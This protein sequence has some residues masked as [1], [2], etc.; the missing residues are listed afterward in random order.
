MPGRHGGQPRVAGYDTDNPGFK[1][2]AYDYGY[3]LPPVLPNSAEPLPP[4]YPDSTHYQQLP[5]MQTSNMLNNTSQSSG[6]RQ[7][8]MHHHEELHEA[9]MPKEASFYPG[10]FPKP[11]T[12]PQRPSAGSAPQGGNYAL[13]DLLY[14]SPCFLPIQPPQPEGQQRGNGGMD[15]DQQ[16]MLASMNVKDSLTS[17]VAPC[18]PSDAR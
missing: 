3:G 10:F 16:R 18:Q 11:A 6:Y 8:N 1:R 4:P 13:A 17:V 12:E 5:S 14:P 7:V 9:Q 15:A 2:E